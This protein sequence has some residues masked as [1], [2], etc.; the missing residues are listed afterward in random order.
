MIGTTI[1]I[2]ALIAGAIIKG[3]GAVVGAIDERKQADLDIE[4]A[5]TQQD[6]LDIRTDQ[7]DLRIGE[8]KAQA[9]FDIETLRRDTRRQTSTVRATTAARGVRGASVNAIQE[10]LR[11]ER[12][13]QIGRIKESRDASVSSENLGQDIYDAQSGL[14]DTR[15]DYLGGKKR[16]AI[17]AGYLGVADAGVDMFTDYIEFTAS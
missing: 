14:L 16:R 7:S 13:R 11:E 2:G 6:I 17:L 1:A 15:I 12:D 4:D 10:G 3:I 5:E 9:A 8:T